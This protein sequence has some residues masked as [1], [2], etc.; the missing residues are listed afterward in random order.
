MPGI[1]RPPPDPNPDR[2]PRVRARA[3]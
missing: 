1:D 3:D 2:P